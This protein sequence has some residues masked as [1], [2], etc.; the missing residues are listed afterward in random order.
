MKG[1]NS[2]MVH[3]DFQMNKESL[4]TQ[5]RSERLKRNMFQ[6]QYDNQDSRQYRK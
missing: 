5:L 6:N 2:Y 4:G 1:Y 3:T